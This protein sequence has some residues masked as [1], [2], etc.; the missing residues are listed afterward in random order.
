MRLDRLQRALRTRVAQLI[1]PSELETNT[2]PYYPQQASCQIPQ[3]HFLLSRFLGERDN[4]IF[5]EVGAYDG[6]FVSNTWGLAERGWRGVMAEP[7]P[8]LAAECRRN[9]ARHP[10]VTV[11]ETAIGSADQHEVV[12]HLAG[13]LTTANPDAFKAYESIEWAADVL[14]DDTVVVPCETLD[15]LLTEQSVPPGFDVLV[16]DVEGFE[17]QVFAGFDLLAWRPRMLIVE[18]AETHPDLSSNAAADARLGR[19]ISDADYVV[20][21]KDHINTVFIRDDVWMD[22]FAT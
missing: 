22:A 1:A 21:F 3:L 11:V 13:T 16:V 12:L 17:A 2:L 20:A 18:L 8:R 9:H 5:V 19:E 7:V 6:I 10:S 4:G 14:T 15:R